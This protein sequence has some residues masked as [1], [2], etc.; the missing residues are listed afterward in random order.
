MP[1]L[2]AAEYVYSGAMD[3]CYNDYVTS[4]STV[5]QSSQQRHHLTTVIQG[6]SLPIKLPVAMIP[7][8][9]SSQSKTSNISNQQQLTKPTE[10]QIHTIS[11]SDED[12]LDAE[13][14]TI[15]EEITN[16]SLDGTE[17]FEGFED[18]TTPNSSG[19]INDI[20]QN[21]HNLSNNCLKRLSN[22]DFNNYY[23]DSEGAVEAIE[24]DDDEEISIGNNEIMFYHS[25]EEITPK[26]SQMH[27]CE[28]HTP[29]KRKKK[30]KE[31]QYFN[32][33]YKSNSFTVLY[34][35]LDY[36]YYLAKV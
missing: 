28:P 27:K 5:Q 10:Q 19:F 12:G 33:K 22:A 32:G 2:L 16:V 34:T 26:K 20:S 14:N 23:E 24:V 30:S 9:N 3:D 1:R 13:Q 17:D 25:R 29:G 6:N 35:M 15:E 4:P 8:S 11:S 31:S 7:E 36:I 21:E 18:Y